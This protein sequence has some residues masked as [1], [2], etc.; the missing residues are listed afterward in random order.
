MGG[1]LACS[2]AQSEMTDDCRAISPRPQQ[3]GLYGLA[4]EAYRLVGIARVGSS[5]ISRVGAILDHDA[6]FMRRLALSASPQNRCAA[7]NRDRC[8]TSYVHAVQ[9]RA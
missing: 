7:F 8:G 4:G 2:V 9:C 5:A 6:E 3:A 1:T